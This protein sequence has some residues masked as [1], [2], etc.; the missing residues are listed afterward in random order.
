M[1]V[2]AGV[3]GYSHLPGTRGLSYECQQRAGQGGGIVGRDE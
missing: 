1:R 2:Y 3:P